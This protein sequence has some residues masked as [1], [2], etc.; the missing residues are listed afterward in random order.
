ML[1]YIKELRKYFERHH[2][3]LSR[4]FLQRREVIKAVDDVSFNVQETDTLG[5]VGESGC[6]KTTLGRT[7]LLLVKPSSGH[8]VFLDRDITNARGAEL[9]WYRRQAQMILQDPIR[10]HNPKSTLK[11]AVSEPIVAH[12]LV[13][14]S[15]ALDRRVDELLEMVGLSRDH[16]Q[17]YPSQ[18]SGGEARRVTIARRLGLSPRLLVCDELTSALD[19]STAAKLLNTMRRIKSELAIAYVWISHDLA[20]VHQ[21]STRILVMYLGKIVEVGSTGDVFGDAQHPYTQLLLSAVPKFSSSVGTAALYSEAV[22]LPSPINPPAY[23]R[24]YSRCPVRMPICHER[25]PQLREIGTG[26]KVACFHIVD[27]M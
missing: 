1:L 8:V 10:R 6:G 9:Q 13:R 4:L 16:K 24:F 21:F 12:K 22:E 26:H 11:R 15:K 23:C 25:A 17:K 20:V 14:G 3:L 7:M 27:E 5:V 19:V 2:D 18:L